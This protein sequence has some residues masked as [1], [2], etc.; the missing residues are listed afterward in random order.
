VYQPDASLIGGLT[1]LAPLARRIEERGL[2][3]TPHTWGDGLAVVANAHLAAGIGGVPYLEF[4]FDPPEWTL[5]R[6]D[7]MLREP[8]AATADGYVVLSDKPGFGV[9]LDEDALQSTRIG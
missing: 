3:F 2:I 5:E 9:E 8:L 4:P 1:G 7:F 6:R